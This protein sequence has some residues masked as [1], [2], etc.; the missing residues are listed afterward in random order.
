MKKIGGLALACLAL[1]GQTAMAAWPSDKPIELVV[2]FAPGGGTDVMAR[3]LARYAEKRLG[4]GARIVVINKPGS[5][6]ELAATY[7]QRAKPDGY[8]LGMINV[9]GYV[10]LPMYRKTSYQPENIRLLARIVDD[11]VML[12]ASKDG[13]KPMTLQAVIDAAKKA[14]ESLSVGHAGEGTTGHLG[15]LDL[16]RQAGIKLNSIPYKGAGDAKVALLGGHVDYVMIT[17]GEALEVSQPGSKL[18]GVAL[19][20]NKRT[21][22]QVPTAAEQGHALRMSSERGIGAPKGLPDD[23]ARKLEDVIAQTLKDPAFLEAAKADAPVLA[24]LPG[25]EWERSLQDLRNRLKPLSGLI[26]K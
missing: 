19:W 7:V 10:F 14:P 20:A 18:A 26:A 15:I 13:G 4:N 2:G 11:P 3:V 12:L 5:A 21:A 16:G 22:N 9:P 17:T 6:G 23:I 8:T 25:A 24:F 1:W